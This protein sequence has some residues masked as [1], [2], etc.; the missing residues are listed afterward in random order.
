MAQDENEQRT[1]ANKAAKEIKKKVKQV[2]LDDMKK[3]LREKL[4]HGRYPLRTDN[5]DADSTTAHQ[6]LSS[7]SLKVEREGFILATQD[8]SLATRMYQ[9]KILKIGADPRCRLCTYSE[10]TIDHMISGCL[11]V[12]NTEYLQRHDR[13][14]KFIHWTLCKHYEIRHTEK[15]YEHTPEP[16]VEGKN[17]TMLWDF[18]VH[19]DRKIDVNRPDIIIKN[20]DERTCIMMDLIWQYPLIKTCH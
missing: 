6:W 9:T 15:W 8:Q 5:G 20:H 13:I 1:E 4:L 11:T 12:A 14:A 7:S 17:V 16:V 18:N 3:T 19:T 2:Y 10:E